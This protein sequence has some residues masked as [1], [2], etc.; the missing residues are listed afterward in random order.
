M[1]ETTAIVG[2]TRWRATLTYVVLLG[3]S[4]PIGT[5]WDEVVGHGLIG[6]LVG[7]RIEHLEILG[8]DLWPKLAWG[9]WPGH[10]GSI[11]VTG[12]STHAGLRRGP[13]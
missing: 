13:G 11:E 1:S 2:S 5:L 12:I 6:V 9:G 3:L 4:L 10:Y 7:G 8:M